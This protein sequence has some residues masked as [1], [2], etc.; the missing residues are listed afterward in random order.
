MDAFDDHELAKIV[1]ERR[2]VKSEAI[3]VS[4]NDL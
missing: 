4:L 1:E 3:E 2:K